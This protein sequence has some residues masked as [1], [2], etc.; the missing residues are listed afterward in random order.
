MSGAGQSVTIPARAKINLALHVV[1][2]RPDGFHLL[3][4]I[5][6]FADVAD[7]ISVAPS[8][9]DSLSITGPFAAKLSDE[10]DNIVSKACLAF[11]ARFSGPGDGYAVKLEKNLPVASGIGGGS[12]DA[13]AVLQ[14]LAALERSAPS[15]RHLAETGLTLGADPVSYAIA[16]ASKQD[17]PLVDGFTVRKEAKQHGKGKQVDSCL[18]GGHAGCQFIGL[19]HQHIVDLCLFNHGTGQLQ[20]V[21]AAGPA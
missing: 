3:D 19:N 12:A 6:A 21:G 9:T 2:R 10:P 7:M 1:G 20:G 15:E 8:S 17:P 11:R 18:S 4:S 5:A 13:A 16:A 14:G